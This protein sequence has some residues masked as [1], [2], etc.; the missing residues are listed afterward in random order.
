MCTG[1]VASQ[2]LLARVSTASGAKAKASST[3]LS[4]LQ[5]TSQRASKL[6]GKRKT[7]KFSDKENQ[8]IRAIQETPYNTTGKKLQ[9]HHEHVK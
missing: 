8:S 4:L 2:L 9:Q 1:L 5:V 3:D 7:D 6:E